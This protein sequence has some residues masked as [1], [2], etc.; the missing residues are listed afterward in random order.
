ML[1][2]P[3]NAVRSQGQKDF[4]SSSQFGKKTECFVVVVVVVITAAA[5]IACTAGIAAAL[6]TS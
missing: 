1:C 2:F 5:G 6:I 3:F 4:F